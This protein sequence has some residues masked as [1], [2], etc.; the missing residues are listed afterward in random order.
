M[1]TLGNIQIMKQPYIIKLT[2]VQK[3]ETIYLRLQF[4]I[5]KYIMARSKIYKQYD[6]SAIMP[7]CNKVTHKDTQI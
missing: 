2:T 5:Q 3:Q 1:K 4:G 7:K 6:T